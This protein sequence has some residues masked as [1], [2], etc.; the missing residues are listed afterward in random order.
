MSLRLAGSTRE[1]SRHGRRPSAPTTEA[2]RH[3]AVTGSA[4]FTGAGP[5]L[6]RLAAPLQ[7]RKKKPRAN[8]RLAGAVMGKLGVGADTTSPV[9]AV[10][11]A[12]LSKGLR[13]AMGSSGSLRSKLMGRAMGSA[14]DRISGTKAA[15]DRSSLGAMIAG[16]AKE[17]LKQRFMGSDI[18][19]AYAFAKGPWQQ[20]SRRRDIAAKREAGS[21]VAAERKARRARPVDDDGPSLG[22][23]FD[24]PAAAPTPASDDPP[25]PEIR[26]APDR[27]PVTL[28]PNV[29]LAP[30]SVTTGI[31]TRAAAPRSRGDDE[32]AGE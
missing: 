16:H 27:S 20:A 17:S 30:V 18:G 3:E 8:A 14:A 2:M 11:G 21:P 25:A 7:L 1:P 29:P 15:G 31:A 19:Q 32:E 6:S 23:S 12:V 9:G 13:G 22:G 5:D 4:S 10:A 28:Q 26:P 24:E